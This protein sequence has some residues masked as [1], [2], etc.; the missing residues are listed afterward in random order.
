MDSDEKAK[1]SEVG[2]V[3]LKKIK[4]DDL[5]TICT[6]FAENAKM[7]V[8]NLCLRRLK[9]VVQFVLLYKHKMLKLTCSREHLLTA[10]CNKKMRIRAMIHKIPKPF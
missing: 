5:Y 9:M 1:T 4:L 7:R 6:L 8:P 3:T 10:V 2:E